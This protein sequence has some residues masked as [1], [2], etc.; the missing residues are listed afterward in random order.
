[1]RDSLIIVSGG[2]DSVTLLYDKK[3]EIGLA[4]TFDYS[5]KHNA[6]EIPFAKYHCEKIG[7]QHLII[8]LG[9]INDYFK[10]SLL[11]SGEAIPEGHYAD[12]NMRTTVVPFRNG[13]MLSIAAGIA[14]SNGLKKVMLANHF[15]DHAIYPDCRASFIE[16]MSRAIENGTYEGVK[17]VAPYTEIDKRE[18]GLIGKKLG[19]DYAKTWT[20]YKG[21]DKHCG[22]CLS[23][24]G[25]KE[26]L[27]GF[28]NTEYQL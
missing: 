14:E 16:P 3:D 10:S 28:D 8:P 20:C 18:I 24:I 7:I 19:I 25:R 12:D 5:S 1:M 21:E 17:I 13:I 4:V 27:N 11:Q 9:F 15:G 26:A 2:M 6:K 23:C 22:V